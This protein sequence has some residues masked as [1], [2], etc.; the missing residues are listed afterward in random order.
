MSCRYCSQED[1]LEC[2]ECRNSNCIHC[3]EFKNGESYCKRCAPVSELFFRFGKYANIKLNKVPIGYLF[4]AQNNGDRQQ[5]ATA[6]NEVKRR[7]EK[8]KA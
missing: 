2:F 8:R 7:K 4:W 5:R 1:K 3:S 6:W